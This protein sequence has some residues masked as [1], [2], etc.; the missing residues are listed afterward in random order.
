[1][2]NESSPTNSMQ[3]SP[4]RRLFGSSSREDNMDT[5]RMEI[6][7]GAGEI[8]E[9]SSGSTPS[10]STTWERVTDEKEAARIAKEAE[11]Q[12]VGAEQST[13]IEASRAEEQRA[14][15]KADAARIVHE[16]GEAARSAYEAE[17]QRVEAD[18]LADEQRAHELAL[19]QRADLDRIAAEEQRAREAEAAA[20]KLKEHQEAARLAGETKHAEQYDKLIQR[21]DERESDT[22][23][24]VAET[25][26]LKKVQDIIDE[27]FD[28]QQSKLDIIPL[29]TTALVCLFSPL[30]KFNRVYAEY[31]QNKAGKVAR[32]V[33]FDATRSIASLLDD[34]DTD[35]DVTETDEV[36]HD[37]TAMLLD[38]K[39]AILCD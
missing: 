38:L 33:N 13:A 32:V 22:S 7:N 24:I 25:T 31:L 14:R 8:D 6:K 2:N 23:L 5:D 21:W 19:E 11:I 39:K 12:R 35:K 15:N 4:K 37:V 20:I 36:C 28:T 9:P 18:R 10:P 17:R 1:M 27:I 29:L 3:L 30:T 34:C 26:M 16:A